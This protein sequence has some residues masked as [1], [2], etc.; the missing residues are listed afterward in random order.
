M[1]MYKFNQVVF[2][3]DEPKQLK[4]DDKEVHISPKQSKLLVYF[5][6]N[7]GKIRTRDEIL[8]AVWGPGQHSYNTLTRTICLLH[9]SL[10]AN[11][12]IKAVHRVGYV[13]EHK[14]VCE[15]PKY[16]KFE[17]RLK[18]SATF[19]RLAY[20]FL[21]MFGSAVVVGS[22]YAVAS[23]YWGINPPPRYELENINP[24]FTRDHIV[25]V[26]RLSPD[27]RFIAHRFANDIYND[28]YI[29]LFDLKTGHT[30][31]VVKLGIFDGF[32]WNLAGDKLV[33][34]STTTGKCEIRLLSFHNEDKTAFS[35]E[36]VTDCFNSSGRLSF[37]WFNERE[38][39]VNFVGQNKINSPNGYPLHHLYSFNIVTKERIK[40][41]SA[42][43]KGGVGYYSLEY[44]SNT[45]TLYFLQTDNFV[46]TSFYQYKNKQLVKL[47][48]VDYLV[49]F[50]T[51]D[52]NRL[53]YKNNLNQFVI[54]QPANLFNDQKLLLRG[55]PVTIGQPHLHKNKL[56]YMA[57][58]AFHFN[59]QQWH[60]QKL[61]G[62]DLQ[63]FSANVLAKM[64]DKLIFASAQTGIFQVYMVTDNGHVKQISDMQINEPLR[65]IE[66]VDD[67]FVLSYI[68]K[69]VLYQFKHQ[70]L[71]LIKTLNGYNRGVLSDDGNTILLTQ[72]NDG[73]STTIY[74]K[75][76]NSIFNNEQNIAKGKL[77]FS[78]HNNIIYLNNDFELIR[79]IDGKQHVV[80]T[81]INV[82]SI[83]Y[84]DVNG[85]D[86]YYIERGEG[87]NRLYKVNL[88]TG[89]K[90]LVDLGQA[91]PSK[92][93]AVGERLFLRTKQI[94]TPTMIIGDVAVY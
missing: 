3:P 57:G 37:A 92:I 42:D 5:V 40:H 45:Q 28:N 67:I 54:N 9:E 77:A 13:F 22:T 71:K 46:T 36:Y 6:E 20:S 56:V 21:L 34:Q 17:Y 44:D 27:G 86:F 65:H 88:I 58:E 26:P 78:H 47:A 2:T 52:N 55:Q 74:Q 87:V 90:I 39:Y 15:A 94:L 61:T 1:K 41:A 72:K 73:A 50:F 81:N 59:L 51:V 84:T 31:T 93:Q 79:L 91:N 14:V 38:F 62:V 12:K 19:K 43:Y 68:D 10:P 66:V 69:V 82:S 7:P 4:Y 16:D 64:A 49:H 83:E 30:R 18:H 80:A 85:D 25:R 8:D 76:L 24:R 23:I 89:D 53:V 35:D 63:Q 60:E 75:Q 11:C 29:G 48:E 33:Y 32:S 70:Q